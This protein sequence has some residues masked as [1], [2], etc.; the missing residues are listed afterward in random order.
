[1]EV[2][3]INLIINLT[4]VPQG[5]IYGLLHSLIAHQWISN[6]GNLHMVARQPGDETSHKDKF[7]MND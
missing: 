7:K 5:I 2:Q 6:N 3:S 1:M 4:T